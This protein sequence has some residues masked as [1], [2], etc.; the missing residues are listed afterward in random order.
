MLPTLVVIAGPLA[1]DASFGLDGNELSIGRDLTCGVCVVSKLVSRRHCSIRQQ[2]GRVSIYD[3]GSRNG[4]FVNGV[5]VRERVLQHGDVIAV[6]DSY[7]R[8]LVPG[9]EEPGAEQPVVFEDGELSI[10]STV[11]LRKEDVR[12]P[13]PDNPPDTARTNRLIRDLGVL[14]TIA[15]RIGSIQE[16]ELLQW[17][18]LGMIFDV[19]PA[20]R[21]AIL[22][23]SDTAQ[24]FTS[25]VAWDRPAG[26]L[27]PMQVSRTVVSRV[28]RE[29]A[30]LLVNDASA[31]QTLKEAQSIVS[32]KAR[33]ILCAP[34][35]FASKTLGAIYLDCGDDGIRFD[36]GHLELLM[37]I[38]GV[39]AMAM[40]NLQRVERLRGEARR[41]Q[42]A[43]D[44]EHNIVGESPAIHQ[45]LTLIGKVARTDSTVLLRGESGTGKELAARAIHRASSRR[46]GPFVAINCA[47][48]PE[49]LLE[50]ELF[51][52][53][54]GAFTG[55]TTQKK[56]QIELAN[57]GTLLL[58]EIGELALG[59]QA[60]LLRVLQEREFTRVGGSRPVK[61]DIRL[62][63]ATNRDLIAAAKAGTFREDLYYRLNVVSVE[64]PPLRDRREDI[65]LLSNYFVS[66][67]G[68]KCKRRVEGISPEAQRCL[69]HYDWP[70]NIRELENAIERA[71]VLGS[72]EFILV[73]DLP[74]SLLEAQPALMKTVA[75]S[76]TDFSSALAPISYHSAVIELKK[77]LITDAVKEA[78]GN[79]TEAARR[80][81]INPTYLH[82]LIRNLNLR[83]LLTS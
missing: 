30:A 50:S 78:G 56:G 74:E 46:E 37:A 20:E 66:K 12:L 26:P 34:L 45:L 68:A 73:E 17:Q 47:A 15:S 70:G 72:S 48:I 83:Q 32:A 7:F 71:V 24:E 44:G 36:E 80:M 4:T 52:Y 76:A 53:D 35:I 29:S 65:W 67:L 1:K 51:G 18:I 57:G 43:L 19:I 82:R 2:D 81:G 79:Y 39:T 59:L 23:C 77:K 33:S 14:V 11:S 10:F 75:D 64:I 60:K 3:L 41:L 13:P 63:A 62:V 6:G 42:A 31:D 27:Q 16:S 61:V 25:Q 22:L 28:L 49:A 55:A 21:G 8:F 54:K 58:D 38:A 69:L 40:A 5:P 9:R